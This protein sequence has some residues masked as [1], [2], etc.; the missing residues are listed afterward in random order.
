MLALFP[1]LEY[2]TYMNF[3]TPSKKGQKRYHVGNS[4]PTPL[5]SSMQVEV[6]KNQLIKSNMKEFAL[7][8]A[9]RVPALMARMDESERK[10]SRKFLRQCSAA[11]YARR[12]NNWPR[13]RYQIIM[14]FLYPGLKR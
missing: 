4:I 14:E 2:G 5:D 9:G 13:C 7:A 11:M 1:E 6:V 12:T 3:V 8:Y 10:K